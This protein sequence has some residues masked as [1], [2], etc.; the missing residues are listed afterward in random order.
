MSLGGCRHSVRSEGW[1]LSS[2][3]PAQWTWR[4]GRG[5]PLPGGAEVVPVNPKCGGLLSREGVCRP[6]FSGEALGTQLC[7]AS[8][9]PLGMDRDRH[10]SDSARAFW[11]LSAIRSFQKHPPSHGHTWACTLP[12]NLCSCSGPS[13]HRSVAAPVPTV[14][15]DIPASPPA[16]YQQSREREHSA[17][18]AFPCSRSW[19]Q[20]RTLLCCQKAQGESR[21]N[22]AGW[23]ELPRLFRRWRQKQGAGEG[24]ESH[25]AQGTGVVLAV[26]NGVTK[27]SLQR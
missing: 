25:A 5:E 22:T 13:S 20:S 17:G 19:G 1:L 11:M 3:R 26:N 21:E 27:S 6:R 16:G 12:S 18:R 23:P 7:P 10:L 4:C 14:T 15:P 8:A 24:G 2:D 9:S